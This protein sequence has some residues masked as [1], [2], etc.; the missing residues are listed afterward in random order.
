MKSEVY[1]RKVDT[2]DLL[3]ALIFDAVARVKKG[4]DHLKQRTILAHE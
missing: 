4:E 2:Y 3:S 1:K